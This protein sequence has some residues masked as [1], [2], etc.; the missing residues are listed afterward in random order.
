MTMELCGM[1]CVNRQFPI[2]HQVLS[3]DFD[4]RLYQSHLGWRNFPTEQAF[5]KNGK[6]RILPLVFR[7]NMRHIVSLIVIVGIA[8]S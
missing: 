5:I 2:R 6:R 8:L 4:P 7:M 1:G 3:T